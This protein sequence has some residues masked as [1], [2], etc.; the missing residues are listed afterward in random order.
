MPH[1]SAQSGAISLADLDNVQP[2]QRT[3]DTVQS[4]Q[5]V[6]LNSTLYEQIRVYLDANPD[7]VHLSARKLQARLNE[8]GII[9]KS[10]STVNNVLSLYKTRT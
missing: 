3:M 9:V 6:Q 7:A 4:V 1:R 5:P 8:N 10:Q 2:V